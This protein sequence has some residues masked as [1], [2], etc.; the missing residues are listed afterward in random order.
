MKHETE[1]GRRTASEQ[2]ALELPAPEPLRPC[3]ECG[4]TGPTVEIRPERTAIFCECGQI[5][6][7]RA[8]EASARRDWNE[9]RRIVPAPVP[10]AT[11]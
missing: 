7:W 6:L 10:L 3:P 9:L 5:G 2:A 4:R 11:T 8:S 1:G